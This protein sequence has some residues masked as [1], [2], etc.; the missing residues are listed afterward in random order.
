[1]ERYL[2]TIHK[3][4]GTGEQIEC[5]AMYFDDATDAWEYLAQCRFNEEQDHADPGEQLSPTWELL[6]ERMAE[7][8]T[9]VGEEATGVVTGPTPGETDLLADPGLSYIVAVI[10]DAE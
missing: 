9:G 10:G 8:T 5:V 6:R 3:P 2:A 7:T 4:I 1:M